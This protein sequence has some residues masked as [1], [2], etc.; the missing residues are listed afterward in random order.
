MNYKKVLIICFSIFV[1]LL[2]LIFIPLITESVLTKLPNQVLGIGTRFLKLLF[3]IFESEFNIVRIIAITDDN[4]LFKI[5]GYI[6]TPLVI[7]LIP[8]NLCPMKMW[9]MNYFNQFP[10]FAEIYKEVQINIF[11]AYQFPGMPFL[12]LGSLIIDFG[13]IGLIGFLLI[14]FLC[15]RTIQMDFSFCDTKILEKSMIFG[16]II[17][18]LV[19]NHGIGTWVTWFTLGFF[20]AN[21]SLKLRRL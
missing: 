20:F 17:T 19:D 9:S 7:F 18:A 21:N 3:S 2:I 10:E 6:L 5:A 16:A 13:L 12:S 4:L 15:F 11:G 1:F 14:L 8:F